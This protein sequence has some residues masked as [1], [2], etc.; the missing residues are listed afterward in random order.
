MSFVLVVCAGVFSLLSELWVEFLFVVVRYSL[1]ERR[2]RKK[3]RVGL[4][5]N[6]ESDTYSGRFPFVV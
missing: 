6:F 3:I 5:G 1:G 4:C 2:A